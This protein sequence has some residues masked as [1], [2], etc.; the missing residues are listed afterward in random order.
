[1]IRHIVFWNL[2]DGPRKAENIL[3]I[4]HLLEGL[5]RQIPQI[6][7]LEVGFNTEGAPQ[8]NWDLALVSDFDDLEALDAYQNHPAHQAVVPV[9]KS[10]VSER[11]CV[12]Y[13]MG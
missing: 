9:I 6:R 8:S 12:D 2:P 13:V 11:A 7:H 3:R 5:V 4:K 10:L 1:M